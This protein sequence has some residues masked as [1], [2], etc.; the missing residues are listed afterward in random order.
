[1]FGHMTMEDAALFVSE[2]TQKVGAIRGAEYD[3]H[4]DCTTMQV[5]TPD[6]ATELSK[7]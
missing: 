2:Y 1:M 5:L 4:V 6:L 3:L 7:S